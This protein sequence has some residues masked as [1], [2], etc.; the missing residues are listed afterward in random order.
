MC[1]V[2]E[3][4]GTCLGTPVLNK[5]KIGRIDKMQCYVT[6]FDNTEQ[7]VHPKQNVTV[8]LLS[9]MSV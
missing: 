9:K 3:A 8:N 4:P 6:W 1:S 5:S 7:V 2:V